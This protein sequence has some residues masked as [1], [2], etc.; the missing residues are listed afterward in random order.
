MRHWTP[1]GIE[2]MDYDDDDRLNKLESYSRI[3]SLGPVGHYTNHF[4]RTVCISCRP[5]VDVHKGEGGPTH[6]DACGQCRGSKT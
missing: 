4:K 1:T 5:C 6:V 2:P 3:S